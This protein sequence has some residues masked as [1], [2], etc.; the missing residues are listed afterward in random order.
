[1]KRRTD[2][3]IKREEKEREKRKKAKSSRRISHY[4][5]Y[6]Y[7]FIYCHSTKIVNYVYLYF[8]KDFKLV[9]VDYK[10]LQ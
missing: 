6:I 3:K 5:K 9:F 10:S 2:K 7:I 4:R 8:I 1:M